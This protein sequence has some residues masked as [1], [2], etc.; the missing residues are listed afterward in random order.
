LKVVT[1]AQM[2]ALEER[3]VAAGA[4]WTGLMQQAGQGV[5]EACVELLHGARDRRIVTLVGP[6]NNGGDGLVA[7]RHLHDAGADVTVIMWHRREDPNDH[8][9]RLVRERGIGELDAALVAGHV[10]LRRALASAELVIDALL[11]AGANRPVEGDLAEIVQLTNEMRASITAPYVVVAIDLPTGI[12]TDSGRVLQ[13]AIR[14]DLT[15]ATGLLKRGLLLYPGRHYA[16]ALHTVPIDL[17]A[18]DVENLMSEQISAAYARPLLPDRPND[19]HKGTY[20]KVLVVA[21]SPAY[22]G[23]ASLATA[24]AARVGAGLVTLATGRSLLGGPGRTPEITYLLL[25][26]AEWGL[27]GEGAADELLKRVGD[28]TALLVG[29]GL[30][31]ETTT[32]RFIERLLGLDAPR[33]R[34]RIGFRVGADP[35]DAEAARPELP[36]TVL[37]ADALN[38]LS[39]A[40]ATD[41]PRRGGDFLRPDGGARAEPADEHGNWWEHVPPGRLVLT[42]HPGEMQRLLGVEKLADDR[43]A[44]TEQAA[45]QWGQIVVLKGATTIVAHP[46]GRTL[47]HDGGNP[48]LAT[49]GTGD[50]LAGSIAGLL[51]Q[52]LE[53]FDAAALGVYLHG[54]AGKLVRDEVGDMGAIATDLLA[55]LPLAIRTLKA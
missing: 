14:A 24:S 2:R 47:I 30:G 44:V 26:E 40:A 28:Y 52:G 18:I 38:M 11:G 51:A 25:P 29:P 46:E 19:S 34:A 45:R 36:P 48:A 16:G 15:I 37:D 13:V 32:R 55:R 20:G 41:E 12:Q 33:R 21:G 22:P 6:G 5:A 50:V 49:A 42:P 7:A 1:A 8:N 3:A 35:E 53:P 9:W 10:Q 54:A 23:A 17:V 4:S 43:V 39:K 27:L 31:Q